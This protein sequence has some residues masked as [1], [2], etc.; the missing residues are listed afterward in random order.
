VGPRP[1]GEPAGWYAR[2]IGSPG[3]SQQSCGMGPR[4]EFLIRTLA[5]AGALVCAGQVIQWSLMGAWPFHDAV[6]NW[7][8]GAHV[9]EGQPVYGRLVG[10]LLGFIYAPPWAIIYAPLSYV[11]Y[12]VLAA[13]EFVFQIAALRYIAGSWRNAGLVAWLPIVPREL[14]TGNFDLIMAA[15]IYA[16]CTGVR[17]AGAALALF[18]F[19]K[20]SPVIALLAQP[21]EWKSFAA[22]SALLVAMTVP[23]LFLWPEWAS[24]LA[25]SATAPLDSIP[26]PYRAPFVIILLALRRPWSIAAAAGL[27]AP[28]FYFHSWVLLLPALRLVVGT[29]GSKELLADLVAALPGPLSRG[30]AFPGAPRS[31]EPLPAPS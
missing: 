26:M 1:G 8:A 16:A 21:R 2:A 23:W 31:R 9:I 7:L 19:A 12:Q 25:A 10:T 30:L 3:R 18:T 17:Y 22:A 11:P 28:A 15:A 20:F 27:A 13:A 24:N 5:V 29:P 14:V 6:T 4:R